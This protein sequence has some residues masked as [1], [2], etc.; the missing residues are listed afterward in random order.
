MVTRVPP[1]VEPKLGEIPVIVW[2]GAA[3][4]KF[5]TNIVP[6]TTNRAMP[7]RRVALAS[8][9]NHTFAPV[10]FEKNGFKLGFIKVPVQNLPN[11]M[12]LMQAHAR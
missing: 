9:A 11:A 3:V 12:R 6:T 4:A 5:G 8:A 2:L 7:A 10:E 1:S